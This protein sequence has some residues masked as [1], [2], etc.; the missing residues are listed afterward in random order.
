MPVMDGGRGHEVLA[1]SEPATKILVLTTFDVD[2]YVIEA[3]L[4]GVSG[5]LKDVRPDELTDAIRSTAARRSALAPM[6]TCALLDSHVG[7]RSGAGRT[8]CCQR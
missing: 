5:F 8:G 7:R 3:I 4:G 1:S 6:A 2:E